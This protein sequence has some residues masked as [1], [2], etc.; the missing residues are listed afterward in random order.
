MLTCIWDAGGTDTIAYNGIHDV[1]INLNAATLQN[2]PGGGGF[3]SYA[4]GPVGGFSI[5][6]AFTIANTVVIEF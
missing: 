4:T 2:A 6:S 3:V 1:I 5:H